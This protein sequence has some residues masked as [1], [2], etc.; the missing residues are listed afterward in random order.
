M[1]IK[2]NYIDD[3]VGIEIVASGCVTGDEIIEI[4]RE[5]YSPDNLKKL[6]YQLIDRTE[7]KEY[8]VSFEDIK[9]IAIFDTAASKSN[10]DIVIAIVSPTDLQFGMSRAW[11]AYVV[12]SHYKTQIFRDRIAA[13]NWLEEQLN[14][15]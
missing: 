10:P 2:I 6:K 1:T 4:Q 9:K 15:T 8:N 13:V 3:G 7:C 11:Q 5:I 14:I 12:D